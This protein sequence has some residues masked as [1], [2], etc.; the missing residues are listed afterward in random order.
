MVRIKF[1]EENDIPYMQDH[2]FLQGVPA[3]VEWEIA[4]I[5]ISR[6]RLVQKS[7]GE[8]QILMEL[9][10]KGAYLELKAPGHG[11]KPYG[12]G[13]IFVNLDELGPVNKGLV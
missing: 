8:G 4:N 13:G 11:G 10:Q 3:D 6:P 2:S 5:S 7:S 12:N 9:V 1:E